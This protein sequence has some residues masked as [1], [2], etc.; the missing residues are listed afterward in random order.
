[1]RTIYERDTAP[2]KDELAAALAEVGRDVRDAVLAVPSTAADAGVVRVAGGDAVFGV[3]ARADVVLLE[4]LQRRCGARW[5]G[6]LVM[7][8]LDEP[9][10]IGAGDAGGEWV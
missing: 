9:A 10:A 3:D 8:G 7:E 1:M 4:S 2:V 5:P 6:A